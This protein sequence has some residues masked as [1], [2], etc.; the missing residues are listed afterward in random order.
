MSLAGFVAV[1][2][3]H[4][5]AAISPGPAVLLSARTGITGGSRTG[6]FL[7]CGLALGAVAWACAALFGLALVFRAVPAVFWTLKVAGAAYLLW[8]AWKMWKGAAE[9]LDTGTARPPR[10]PAMAF[11]L[12]LFAQLANPKPALFFSAVFVG[13][14]PPATPAP[15]IAALILVVFLNE[16]LW[17][18]LVVR[19][20]SLEPARKGYLRLKATLDRTFGGLLA[21]LG[22]KLAAT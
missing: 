7:A 2:L 1:A 19:V 16:A 17:N 9:P 6:I 11:R 21:L 18:L 3:I 8:L 5:M 10:S 4:L 15:V 12:G 22:L 14:V 13:L 20:F